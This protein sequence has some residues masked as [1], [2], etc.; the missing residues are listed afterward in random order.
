MVRGRAAPYI[1]LAEYR[2]FLDVTAD[3]FRFELL[4]LADLALVAYR[5]FRRRRLARLRIVR[6][7]GYLRPRDAMYDARLPRSPLP[8]V[9]IEV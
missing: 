1:W 8:G 6:V 9:M 5:H 3:I 2:P 7:L 4:A